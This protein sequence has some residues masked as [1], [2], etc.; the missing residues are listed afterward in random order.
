[1][2]HMHIDT[3]KGAYRLMHP[4][5]YTYSHSSAHILIK[6]IHTFKRTH[7]P[8][9]MPMH[10]Y[11]HT[12]TH[13][14]KHTTDS[15]TCVHVRTYALTHIKTLAHFC[16]GVRPPSH[17]ECPGYDTKQSD[18]EVPVMLRPWGIRSTPSLPL[19]RGPLWP[20]VVAPDRALSIS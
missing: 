18:G 10:T 11:T 16:R 12:H 5:T 15:C 1:M 6:R 8:T 9:C 17:N 14:R 4:H 3:F 19:L 13:A 20:G 7:I 2:T